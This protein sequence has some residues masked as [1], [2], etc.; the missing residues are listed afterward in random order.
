MFKQIKHAD[1]PPGTKIVRDPHHDGACEW[2]IVW[3]NYYHRDARDH[4]GKWTRVGKF[5]PTPARIAILA[6]LSE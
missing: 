2:C 5:H 3:N 4:S 1:L 6:S